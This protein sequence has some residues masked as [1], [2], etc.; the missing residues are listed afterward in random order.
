MKLVAVNLVALVGVV[1]IA[2]GIGYGPTSGRWGPAGL[3][4]MWA[5]VVICLGAAV[6]GALPV[7][8]VGLWWR[9]YVGHAAIGGMVIRLLLTGSLAL[10]CQHWGDVHLRSC[11]AGMVVLYLFLLV[12]ETVI[13]VVIVRTRWQAPATSGR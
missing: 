6:A 10:G 7:A 2:V 9:S 5:A 8:L 11:L 1:A 12:V 4:S 3:A 13:G